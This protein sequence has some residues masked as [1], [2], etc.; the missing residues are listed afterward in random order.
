[1]K[2]KIFKLTN[3]YPWPENLIRELLNV[4]PLMETPLYS[5]K[6]FNEIINNNLKKKAKIV[7]Y[8]HYRDKYTFKEIERYFGINKTKYPFFSTISLTFA[9]NSSSGLIPQ[10]ARILSKALFFFT[11]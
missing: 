8:A 10:L 5:E 9:F 4:D 7:I 11:L 6:L 3:D 2:Q 1:M